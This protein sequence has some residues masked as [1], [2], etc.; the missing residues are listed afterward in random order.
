MAGPA[1]DNRFGAAV[2]TLRVLAGAALAGIVEG[3]EGDGVG[4]AMVVAVSDGRVRLERCSVVSP[5][6]V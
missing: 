5:H 3:G 2:G 4:G 1:A 6:K